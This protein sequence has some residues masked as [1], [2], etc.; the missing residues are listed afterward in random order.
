MGYS[1]T[2]KLHAYCDTPD[3][4]LCG[5]KADLEDRRVVTEW[6]AREFAE[7][8]GL[9]YL[10]TSAATG[11]NVSRAV[12]T[13]LEKVMLRMETAVDMAMVPGQSGKF[14]DTGEFMLRSSSPAQKCTC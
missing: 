1:W 14:K 9:P 5:N 8:N 2:G 3:I 10:E 11:Q 6:R 13:L 12:E 4:V 7:I